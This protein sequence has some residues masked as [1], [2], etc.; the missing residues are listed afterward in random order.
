[1]NDPFFF[2]RRQKVT[3]WQHADALEQEQIAMGEWIDDKT[4]LHCMAC[5][6][7]FSLLSRKVSES[8]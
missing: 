5:N 8:G 1:M 3:L 6:T 7:L 2:P 4:V